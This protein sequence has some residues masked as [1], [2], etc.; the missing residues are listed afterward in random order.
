MAENSR[1]RCCS[2]LCY[3]VTR[4]AGCDYAE[5]PSQVRPYAP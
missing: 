3:M 5:Y 2:S 4:D 1:L